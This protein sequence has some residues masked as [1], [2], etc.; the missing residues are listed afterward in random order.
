MRTSLQ[1]LRRAVELPREDRMIFYTLLAAQL[2]AGI[3][4]AKACAEL[5]RLEGLSTAIRRLAKAGA[6][7]AREGRTEIDGMAGTGLLPGDELAVLR[8]A[9]R[10]GQ[11]REAL[12][13]LVEHREEDKGFFARVVYP[14]TYYLLVTALAIGF[15]WLAGDFFASFR[16]FGDGP[17]VLID[18]SAAMR[19]WLAPVL[20][21]LAGTAFLVRAGMRSWIGPARRLLG[22]FDTQARLQYGVRFARLAGMMSRRGAVDTEILDAVIETWRESR[23]LLHHATAAREAITVRGERWE[24]ALGRGL[25]LPDHAALLRGLVPGSD[26]RRYPEGYRAVGTVQRVMLE[27]RFGKMRTVLKAALLLLAFWM[28]STMLRGMYTILDISRT[29]A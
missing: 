14:N 22:I 2:R 25:L 13:E 9:D 12:D 10:Y 23:Y 29:L 26:L 19:D 3:V 20:A 11:L 8:I 27:Q 1:A 28:I 18:L 16:V 6:Q 21:V 17:N 24:E 15:V 4:P 5:E 7:A